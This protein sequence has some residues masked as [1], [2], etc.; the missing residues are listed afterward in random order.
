MCPVLTVVHRS[1]AELT[2]HEYAVVS[3]HAT[4]DG[5][6]DEVASSRQPLRTLWQKLIPR[7]YE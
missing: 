5:H 2:Q 3:V 1:L 6:L 7:G 4:H